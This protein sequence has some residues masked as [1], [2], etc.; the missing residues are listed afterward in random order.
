MYKGNCKTLQPSLQIGQTKLC[1]IFATFQNGCP[2]VASQYPLQLFSEI[3]SNSF[4]AGMKNGSKSHV[5]KWVDILKLHQVSPA[6]L[7]LNSY[8]NMRYGEASDMKQ[9]HLLSGSFPM[10]RHTA[11]Q[12]PSRCSLLCHEMALQR[13]ISLLPKQRCLTVELHR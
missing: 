11:R 8:G 12:A 10:Y 7:R 3:P 6:Y 5:T 9:R 4:Q 2:S 1:R 13:L